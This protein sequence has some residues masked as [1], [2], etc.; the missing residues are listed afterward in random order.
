MGE[1]NSFT[2]NVTSLRTTHQYLTSTDAF[3]KSIKFAC[4]TKTPLLKVLGVEGF[5]AENMTN[6]DRFASA[7]AGGMIREMSGVY[8]CAGSIFNSYP[9]SQLVGRMTAVNPQLVEGGTEW[10]YSWHQMV[11]S[12]FIPV[13]DVQDNGK[14]LIDIKIKNMMAMKQQY[15]T[16]LS[17]TLLGNSAAPSYGVMG[18]SVV[19]SDIPN[20]ISVTQD[21]TVGCIPTAS[22]TFW[23]N[24]RRAITSIGGGGEMDRPL[25]LRRAWLKALND[26]MK[27]G[28]A[29]APSDYLYVATQGAWQYFDRM[30]YA[31]AIETG[32]GDFGVS[33]RYDP[34][35]VQAFAF[36]GGAVVWD[37]SISIPYGATAATEAIYGIH[38]PSFFLSIRSEENFKMTDWEQPRAHDQFKT[39]ISTLSTRFTLGTDNRRAHYV[40]YNIPQNAD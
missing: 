14:G 39:L 10:K 35:G 20:L 7:K 26:Q 30:A 5:G 9:T 23:Q 22:N 28:E 16:D 36:N 2:G 25:L 15:V 29:S 40:L 11:N 6:V 18:P 8:A 37:P 34:V 31:D 17:N 3:S 33:R 32:K 21:R 12:I 1:T 38:K 4:F 27:L 19:Y 24:G 13:N